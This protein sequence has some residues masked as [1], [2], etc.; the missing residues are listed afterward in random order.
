MIMFIK[1][2]LTIKSREQRFCLDS[3]KPESEMSGPL[4]GWGTKPKRRDLGGISLERAEDV[5]RSLAVLPKPS[6]PGKCIQSCDVR[7]SLA[8]LVV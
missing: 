2:Q 3:D 4:Q 8:F 7:R 6:L 5:Q 1:S